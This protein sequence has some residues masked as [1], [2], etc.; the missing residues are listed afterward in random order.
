MNFLDYART[1]AGKKLCN[2]IL[3][4]IDR[5]RL[6]IFHCI[7]LFSKLKAFTSKLDRGLSISKFKKEIF[8]MISYTDSSN[9]SLNIGGSVLYHDAETL[10]SLCHCVEKLRLKM[11]YHS[12]SR[13]L[14][15]NQKID[16]EESRSPRDIPLIEAF[17]RKT[18]NNHLIKLEKRMKNKQEIMKNRSYLKI[19]S[20]SKAVKH[21]SPF[22]PKNT[23]PTKDD[24]CTPDRTPN[25]SGYTPE[26][27]RL[28]PR[29]NVKTHPR[30]YPLYKMFAFLDQNHILIL[31]ILF[32][33]WKIIKILEAIE[34]KIY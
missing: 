15:F 30:Y 13:I 11:F 28:T 10:L 19:I 5:Y 4:S 16:V 31:A 6:S 24:M 2:S 32:K 20:Y 25:K 3:R 21:A 26:R 7:L 33:R 17:Y 23:T 29:P 18:L 8:S 34:N 14:Y 9:V 27:Y 12:F 22:K 1:K